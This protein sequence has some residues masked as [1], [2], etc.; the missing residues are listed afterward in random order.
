MLHCNRC[1]GLA[2]AGLAHLHG[3]PCRPLCWDCTA[4]L[5]KQLE[6]QEQ[7]KRVEGCVT[8]PRSRFSRNLPKAA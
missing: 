1:G 3:D 7:P 5:L 6:H 4:K 2:L 8:K